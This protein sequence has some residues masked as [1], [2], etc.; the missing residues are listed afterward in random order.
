[1]RKD[2]SD[3][4][5]NDWGTV[6]SDTGGIHCASGWS[7]TDRRTSWR[8]RR[9]NG[10]RVTSPLVDRRTSRLACRRRWMSTPL[11]WVRTDMWFTN[12]TTFQGVC[13]SGGGCRNTFGPAFEV[14]RVI[15]RPFDSGRTRKVSL[16]L[17]QYCL[18][19]TE[20]EGFYTRETPRSYIISPHNLDLGRIQN[21]KWKSL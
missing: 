5:S 17:I 8:R 20:L 2:D 7:T 15:W 13:G 18:E 1:M 4:Q 21:K 19:G 10:W 3:W 14:S 12:F 6:V 9:M 16:E 11:G